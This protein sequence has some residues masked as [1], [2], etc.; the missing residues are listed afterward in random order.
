MGMTICLVPWA[1]WALAAGRVRQ[2]DR[3]R[4]GAVIL[5]SLL[6]EQKVGSRLRRLP[7]SPG[8]LPHI[9]NGRVRFLLPDHLLLGLPVL[10]WQHGR[11]AV[12]LRWRQLDDDHVA[13]KVLYAIIRRICDE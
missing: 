2:Q 1:G 4:W 10:H 13:V 6:R 8:S 3:V 7:A 9:E 12:H 11:V 5:S